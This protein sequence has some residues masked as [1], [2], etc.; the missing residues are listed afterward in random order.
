MD[1]IK[2]FPFCCHFRGFVGLLRS[3]DL[4]WKGVCVAND[5]VNQCGSGGFCHGPMT[6]GHRG[7]RWTSVF[8]CVLVLRYPPGCAGVSSLASLRS[9]NCVKC[10]YGGTPQVSLGKFFGISYRRFLD[11]FW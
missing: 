8:L 4:S 11:V 7:L 6:V 5:F 10:E 9:G 2:C 3:G 1:F